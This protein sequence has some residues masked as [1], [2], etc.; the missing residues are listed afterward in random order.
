M[1]KKKKKNTVCWIKEMKM[2]KRDFDIEMI[3]NYSVI[4]TNSL[5]ERSRR[6][7]VPTVYVEVSS[8]ST[9]IIGTLSRITL[10]WRVQFPIQNS[11]AATFPTTQCGDMTGVSYGQKSLVGLGLPTKCWYAG[12]V[13]IVG[14]RIDRLA[15]RRALL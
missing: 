12:H 4:I 15:P 11:M 8:L 13:G 3:I 7:E 10:C 5:K 2:E 14:F 6:Y 9:G 1:K